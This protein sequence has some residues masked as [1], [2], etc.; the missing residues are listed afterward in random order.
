M[1]A[2]QRYGKGP[3]AVAVYKAKKIV[4]AKKRQQKKWPSN[5]F[6]TVHWERGTPMSLTEFGASAREATDDQYNNRMSTGMRGRG[7][8]W[9]QQLG[10]MAGG[11]LGARFGLGQIGASLGSKLGD[12]GSDYVG[13]MFGRGDY[14]SGQNTNS[15]ITSTMPNGVPQFS[16]SNDETGALT[17][18]HRE[19]V[20]DILA[21]SN[22][23]Q[24]NTFALNPGLPASFPWLSQI[25][26]SYEEYEFSGLIFS[27]V[28]TSQAA[29][30]SNNSLG[31]VVLATN[32]NP[33]SAPFSNKINMMEFDAS[34]SARQDE[35]QAHGVEC[36]PTKN[37]GTTINYVRT[38]SVPTGQ[39]IKTFDLG[40]FQ[41]ALNAISGSG[42]NGTTYPVQVGELWVSYKVVLRKP[43]LVPPL[44]VDSGTA[45]TGTALSFSAP[46]ASVQYANNRNVLA[47][48]SGLA[49]SF[50]LPIGTTGAY[51]LILK[52]CAA[53]T[54][55]TYT[56]ITS[57]TGAVA[58]TDIDGI[59]GITSTS[60]ASNGGGVFISIHDFLVTPVPGV[61][62]TVF[63][64]GQSLATMTRI[65]YELFPINVPTTTAG[66]F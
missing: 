14:T 55:N 23:F 31:T 61:V 20:T 62:T 5:R 6:S 3:G 13:K 25:A 51:R 66:Y 8:Y 15:L 44:I 64:T 65:S 2:P 57:S 60:V 52:V 18:S 7:A 36:D 11:A 54:G 49:P 37:A 43:M 9:G 26:S 4:A 35:N 28:S 38:G 1:P 10:S 48:W 47:T 22:G 53:A 45:Y 21:F 42:A 59:S 33:A 63:I 40:L 16:S 29:N 39:D 27:F 30:T 50:T 34:Q 12:I 46:F 24:N 19:Y 56:G 32:Y 41:I 58:L 17:I